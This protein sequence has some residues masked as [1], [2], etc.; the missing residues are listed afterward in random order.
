VFGAVHVYGVDRWEARVPS[1]DP[2]YAIEVI[3]HESGE[4]LKIEGKE[5]DV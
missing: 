2:H 4:R 5:N 3:N 1:L